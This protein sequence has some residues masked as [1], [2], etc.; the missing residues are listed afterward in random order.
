LIGDLQASVLPWL[1]LTLAIPLASFIVCFII[2]PHFAW[3]TPIVS[4]LLMVVALVMCLVLFITRLPVSPQVLTFEWSWVKIATTSILFTLLLDNY[5]LV[6]SLMVVSVSTLVHIYSAGYMV[7]D[8]SQARFFCLLGIFTFAMLGVVFSGNLFVL[9]CFWEL[10]GASSYLLIGH[11]RSRDAA[12]KAAAKAFMFNRIGDFGF[13]VGLMIIWRSAGTFDIISLSQSDV[14]WTTAAGLFIFLG[15]IAK[16]AQLPLM[17]WLPDAMEGPTPV[18]ALIHAATMVAAGVYI[19][20]RLQFLFSPDALIVIGSIGALTALYSGWL[21]LRENDLKRI[22]AYSTVSQ[23]GVMMISIGMQSFDGAFLHLVTHGFF[24]ACLFL[25]AGALVYAIGTHSHASDSFN[26]QDIRN[27]G[28]L[29]R[30]FPI[31]FICF[32]I[33]GASLAGVPL[34]S[35]FISKEAMLMGML[36]YAN[37]W[38]DWLFIGAFMIASLF[39]VMYTYHTI[40]TIFFGPKGASKTSPVPAVMQVPTLICA[41]LCMSFFY[42]FNPLG[43]KAW[44]QYIPQLAPPEPLVPVVSIAWMLFSLAIA[45][46][47]QRKYAYIPNTYPLPIDKG[48]DR[49]VVQP[50]LRFSSVLAMLDNRLLDRTAH[51]FVYLQVGFA[52]ATGLLD[53]YVVDG[54]V[55]AIAWLVR[56]LGD[57]LRS[58][59]MGRIQLYLFWAFVGFMVLVIWIIK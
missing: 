6:M 20:L 15:A 43:S 10:V 35:G 25:G 4:S 42:A 38:T 9:F 39:T 59:G 27:M 11:W 28:G 58:T 19:L 56:R 13:I 49:F 32:C 55:N 41:G 29:R 51:R 21:A 17:T 18:S 34:F 3:V 50:V 8:E 37:H 16:S 14:A 30:S 23:L 26:A 52:K 46:F 12:A 7:R 57:A 36:P 2:K 24:K 54:A 47:V 1:L 48:Y 5:S 53:K 45:V 40:A 33:A 22:L 44:F 31:V